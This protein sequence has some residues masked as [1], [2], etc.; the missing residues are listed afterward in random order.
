MDQNSI[1]VQR[2]SARAFEDKAIPVD[3]IKDIV[4]E[5]ALAPSWE[6]SQPWK[7][8]VATGETVKRIRRVTL[9]WPARVRRVGRRLCHPKVGRRT[10]RAT[11]TSGWSQPNNLWVMPH[12]NFL[13]PIKT[14]STRLPLSTSR[15][16]RTHHTIR[17]TMPG[18]LGTAYCWRLRNTAYAEFPRTSLFVIQLRSGRRLIF[19]KMSR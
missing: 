8:Y 12:R 10:R 13:R 16:L 17:R 4:R 19:P 11:L 5:A 1:L 14:C 15:F 3:V 7:A 9:T 2:H 18:R 6:N